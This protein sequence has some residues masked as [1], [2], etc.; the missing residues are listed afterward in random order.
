MLFQ[1]PHESRP[2]GTWAQM[3]SL[4]DKQVATGQGP[5]KLLIL[6]PLDLR[7]VGKDRTISQTPSNTGKSHS[8]HSQGDW[9]MPWGF[10]EDAPR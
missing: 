5:E 7:P 6:S 3:L 4:L 1:K 9:S 8:G 10:P 2:L